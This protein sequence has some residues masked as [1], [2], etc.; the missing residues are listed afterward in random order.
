MSD[1]N[2]TTREC[3]V[4]QLHPELRQAIRG[5]FKEHG[6]GEPQA[7]TLMCCETISEKKKFGRLASILKGA[8]DTMIYTGMLLTSQW[9]IWVRKGDQSGTVL[10]AADLKEIQVKA[11]TSILA[12]DAGLEISGYI[13]GSKSLIRGYIG[14]GP[15][16]A[17]Q[18]FCEEVKKAV[19]NVNPPPKKGWPKWMGG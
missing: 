6:L 12:Q 13:E 18:K 10:T 1:Y 2:R 19:S 9:L 15:E 3:T 17:A 16:L 8:G 14:M 5:Y 11:Y 7:E 4:S